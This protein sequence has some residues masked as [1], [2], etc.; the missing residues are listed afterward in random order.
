[1]GAL[2]NT[3]RWITANT[4]HTACRLAP[5]LPFPVAN[6]LQGILERG[7]PLMPVLARIV[8]RNMRAAGVYD[9]AVF[10]GY[11]REV[12]RHL[13]NGLRIFKLHA[14][15]EAVVGLARR[16]V[17]VDATIA[18][19]HEAMQQGRGAILA[20]AHNCNYLISLTRLRQDLPF[21]VYLR[22]SA[23]QRKLDLKRRWCRAAGLDVIIEPPNVGNPAA[24][25]ALCVDALREGRLLIMTPDIAQ[26]SSEGVEVQWL[27]RRAYLPTGPASLAMLAEVPIIPLFGYERAGTYVVYLEEPIAVPSLSRAEGGRKEAVRRAMQTWA[28]GFSKFIRNSPQAWFLWGDSRWTRVLEGDPRYGGTPPAAETGAN[29]M[30]DAAPD[31]AR[32]TA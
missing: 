16:E 8:E 17:D 15:P 1:M 5:G 18:I 14:R 2:R 21:W 13:A 6:A 19:A 4:V 29:T 10:R 12:A 23:D 3:R 26:K 30:E 31:P 28:D 24:R 20:P 32:E 27:D 22:W 25:A 7:G 11:F 9:R